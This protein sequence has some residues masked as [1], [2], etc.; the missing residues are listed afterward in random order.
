[1]AARIRQRSQVAVGLV[2]DRP[3]NEHV[4]AQG[5]DRPGEEAAVDRDE[6]P[7]L[8][9]LPHGPGC[10]SAAQA[11]QIFRMLQKRKDLQHFGDSRA[12]RRHDGEGEEHQLRADAT[13]FRIVP[14]QPWE[15]QWVLPAA[16]R[17]WAVVV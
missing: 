16:H 15:A 2:E 11:A 4:A 5:W 12:R 7:C 6:G 1:M 17:A 13:A 10:F 8:R 14:C 3:A 9:Q